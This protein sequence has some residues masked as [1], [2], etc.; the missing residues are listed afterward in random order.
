[1]QREQEPHTHTHT[2]NSNITWSVEIFVNITFR[3]VLT[4]RFKKIIILGHET[5]FA[6]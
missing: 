4:F 5:G 2:Q 1:M 6:N 3:K